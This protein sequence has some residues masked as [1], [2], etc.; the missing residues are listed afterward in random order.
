MS[1]D[2]IFT[3]RN[4]LKVTINLYKINIHNIVSDLRRHGDDHDGVEYCLDGYSA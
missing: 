2:T 3:L 4:N 1:K